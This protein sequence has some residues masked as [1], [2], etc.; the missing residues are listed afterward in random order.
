[1]SHEIVIQSNYH[2]L[3][4]L[5]DLQQTTQDFVQHA[6]SANTLNAYLSD[7]EDFNL[8]CSQRQLMALPGDPQVVARYLA[9][10]AAHSWIGISGKKRELKEK[11]PL[12]VASLLRRLTTISRMHQ[13]HN[14]PFNRRHPDI[15]DVMAGIKRKLGVAQHRKDPILIEDLRGMVENLPDTLIGVRNRSL[16]LMGFTGAFRRSELVSLCYEDLKFK[17][18]GI[19]VTL[20]RSKVDQEGQGRILPIP[21]GSN[22]S[23]CPV[24]AIQD[25]L[26]LAQITSGFLFRATNRHGHILQK[27]LSDRSVAL[28]IKHNHYIQHKIKAAQKSLSSIPDY[29]GHSLRAGFVTTAAS[30]GVSEHLIMQQTGHKKSDTV[31]KYIRLTNMWKDNAAGKL[32]L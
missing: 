4:Q 23:T 8:W 14:Y 21:F 22:P 18:E 26:N 19:E 27:A 16:L 9:D 7:W 28:I 5:Q 6:R 10:R 32:G 25:W 11:P 29:A 15:E 24:R 3:E 30:N 2:V 20:R 12:K 1:M 17:R 13:R 31:K